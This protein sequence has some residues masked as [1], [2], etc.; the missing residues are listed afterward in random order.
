VRV[1]LTIKPFPF[2]LLL[3]TVL[4]L[5]ALRPTRKPQPS[6]GLL[7]EQVKAQVYDN[8]Q[9]EL[10]NYGNPPVSRNAKRAH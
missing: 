3:I 1:S 2:A 6:L 7:K 5:V 10:E 4:M 9:E 8:L